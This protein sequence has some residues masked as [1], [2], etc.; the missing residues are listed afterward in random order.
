MQNVSTYLPVRLVEQIEKCKG[1]V[2]RNLFIRRAI[3]QAVEK[4]NK[5]AENNSAE[6]LEVKGST[7]MPQSAAKNKPIFR[8]TIDGNLGGGL[9]SD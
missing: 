8:E 9:H 7:T 1:D 4:G 6:L 3:L 5:R 2:S